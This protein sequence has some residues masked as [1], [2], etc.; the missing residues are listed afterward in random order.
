M[1][2]KKLLKYCIMILQFPYD[3]GEVSN[4][5]EMDR[6]HLCKAIIK[7]LKTHFSRDRIPGILLSDN[8]PQYSSV[9]SIS[10]NSWNLSTLHLLHIIP[11]I[12]T[13]LRV[14]SR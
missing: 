9:D 2:S 8:G 5:I 3:Y 11:R 10:H 1:A 14:L 12:I 6:L 7:A 4:F 13:R